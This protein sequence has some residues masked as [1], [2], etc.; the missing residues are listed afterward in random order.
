[1]VLPGNL[2]AWLHVSDPF[3]QMNGQICLLR[4][5]IASLKEQPDQ[6][7]LYEEPPHWG[8]GKTA[9]P[10]ETATLAK[11]APLVTCGTPLPENLL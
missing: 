5:P 4:A 1:M 6:W 8:A 3:N 11:T 10:A 9:A 2:L 7:I